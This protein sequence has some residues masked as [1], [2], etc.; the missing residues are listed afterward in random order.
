MKITA[1]GQVMVP[2]AIRE[3]PRVA[4]Q[5]ALGSFSD[6]AVSRIWDGQAV[7]IPMRDFH[8]AVQAVVV[9]DAD[10]AV[11]PVDNTI[12][13]RISESREAISGTPDA[14]VV[15]EL[16][17]MVRQCLL[18]QPGATIERLLRVF[19][20]PVALAQCKKFLAMYPAM[21]PIE[22][23]DTAGAAAE[24]ASRGDAAEAAFAPHGAAA[25]HGLAVLAPDVQDDAA[26]ATRFAILAS[27][28]DNE[29][30]PSWR[31]APFF[32]QFPRE[33]D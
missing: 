22:A 14:F 2:V 33:L 3:Q 10:Y 9:S 13:G 20:H 5:G 7:L 27:A 24:V 29:H 18:G 12:V 17:L 8:A 1:N 19:S 11:L 6:E 15:G 30:P 4:F 28:N 26:N 25:R 31:P 16:T 23:Y 21:V 32:Y